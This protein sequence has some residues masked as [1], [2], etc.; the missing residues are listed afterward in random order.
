MTTKIAMPSPSDI[1]YIEPGIF[2]YIMYVLREKHV[3]YQSSHA[4]LIRNEVIRD[5][6]WKIECSI[7]PK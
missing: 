4:E 3:D 5:I 7:Q 6:R 2:A 1:A